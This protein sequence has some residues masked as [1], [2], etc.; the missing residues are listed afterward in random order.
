MASSDHLISRDPNFGWD[1]WLNGDRP[2][3][4]AQAVPALAPTVYTGA[5]TIRGDINLLPPGLDVYMSY[6]D[7]YGGFPELV[8][9][10]DAHAPTAQVWSIT[11]FGGPAMVADMEPGAMHISD[12][13]GWYDHT[14]DHGLGVPV[15]YTSASNMGMLISA[16]GGRPFIKWSAHYG[17]GPHI[18]G[19]AT[20]G[21][22]QA[23]W[24]QWDDKGAQ[25]QNFDRS[26]GLI[27][28][29]GSPPPPSS[30]KGSVMIAMAQNADGRLEAFSALQDGQVKHIWQTQPSG[31]WNGKPG[32]TAYYWANLG[33][34]G[35][36]PVG[37]SAERNADGR[38]EI[39][40]RLD[41]GSAVHTWQ[42]APGGSWHGSQP[43]RNA[44]WESF[45]NPG[46]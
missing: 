2:T 25:G 32:V 22:P 17:F 40:V 1:P 8:A 33:S 3:A 10:R 41:D 14:A 29:G 46:N 31:S 6:V 4:L 42:D 45:G 5:D 24:T 34:T 13:A 23:D 15:G 19:P 30:P 26:L 44:L 21:W 36:K 7:N 28:P 18:C 37:I 12:F 9:W 11:I 27:L 38:L 35:G 39:A 16:A 20:C 43:G